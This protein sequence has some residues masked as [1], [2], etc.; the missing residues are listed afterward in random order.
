MNSQAV[1]AEPATAPPDTPPQR[2]GRW[3]T[4]PRRLTLI[5]MLTVAV[6]AAGGVASWWLT[7]ADASDAVEEEPQ[8]GEILTLEPM[9]VGLSAG[10]RHARVG[11]GLVLVEGVDPAELEP[12]LPLLKDAALERVAGLPH[13]EL[14]TPE[15]MRQLRAGLST[16][17]ARIFDGDEPVVL[18]AILTELVVQ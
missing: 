6:A 10:D 7:S 12:R 2:S 1:A 9:T 4:T 8:E 5:V 18:R 17:A 14:S 3:S 11:V 13:G 15:G 16:D